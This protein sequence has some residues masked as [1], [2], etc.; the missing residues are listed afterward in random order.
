MNFLK[1]YDVF[2]NGTGVMGKSGL[3]LFQG[4]VG[5]LKEPARGFLAN[6]LPGVNGG[7][8]DDN[9]TLNRP[10]SN[11]T[12][13]YT[14]NIDPHTSKPNDRSPGQYCFM[15]RDPNERPCIGNFQHH[16][17][18][19]WG[20]FNYYLQHGPGRKRYEQV[21]DA[22][23]II[24]EWGPVGTV[25][26]RS[27][28]A[29]SALEAQSTSQTFHFGHITETQDIWATKRKQSKNNPYQYNGIREGSSLFGLLKRVREVNPYTDPKTQ[30][31]S[32]AES[33]AWQNNLDKQFYWRVE[34]HHEYQVALPSYYLY[35]SDDPTGI[36]DYRG[37]PFPMGKCTQRINRTAGNVKAISLA[38]DYLYPQEDNMDR[39]IAF[40][41]LPRIQVD[42]FVV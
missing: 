26:T 37:Y 3:G 17:I 36:N 11:Q 39:I 12:V 23:Q 7:R 21:R 31:Y 29:D 16:R 25:W 14:Y 8:V 2:P 1:P 20:S 6:Q 5:N 27:E 22:D 41:E 10:D 42:M 35:N 19:G 4:P 33:L 28:P 9:N 40:N 13:V 30:L 34:P 32:R 24:K 38:N 18:L 15:Y